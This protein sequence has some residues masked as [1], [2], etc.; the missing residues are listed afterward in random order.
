MKTEPRPSKYALR[1]VPVLALRPADAAKAL[2]ISERKLWE[3]TADQTSGIPHV[4]FGKAIRYPTREL[5]DW[6]ADRARK[7][8]GAT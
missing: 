7:R 1:D 3:I 4:R 6:L 2:G 8:G 5:A